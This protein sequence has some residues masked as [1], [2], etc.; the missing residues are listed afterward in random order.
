MTLPGIGVFGTGSIVRIIIPFLREK[1]FRIEAIWGRTLAEVSEVAN[2]LQIPFHTSRIDD[3]LLRKDVDLIFI[4]CSP[5][6]HSQIAVK[7]LGIGKHVVCDKPAGLSQSEALKMVRA[8]Q[9][10]PSLI[11]IVN[12]SLRF[13]PAFVHMKKVLEDGY[14]SGP[15]TVIEIRVHMGSLL[16]NG[17]DWLCDDTMG[18]GIL[19]LV[20]SHV[21]DLIFHLMGQ[22]ASR[23]HAV[24]RTFTQSTKYI[25]GIRHVTSPDFCSFQMELSG[26]TLVTATLSN[27]LQGQ[28][29]Q[30]VLICGGGNHLIVRGGDLYGCRGEQEEILYRDTDDLQGISLP[31]VDSI[32]RPYIKGLR[33]MIAAL[34][35]AFQSVEDKRGWIKEPVF[36]ASTFED[37]LYVQAVID[38]LRQSNK[39]RGWAKVNILTEEPDPNP[40]LSAAVRATAISI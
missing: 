1:G 15:V 37:G 10:Y 27:H 28:L 6:L 40:L 22:R 38:A 25:N 16:H 5:S 21:I 11:S 31:I 36:S 17:Y 13:L 3:V 4:M 23:V 9:Y 7:A 26:G 39:Q 2:D 8:A 32:P 24:V 12:H 20:G 35:E 18:G 14:L 33:K 30:E 29:S 19:A 34:R